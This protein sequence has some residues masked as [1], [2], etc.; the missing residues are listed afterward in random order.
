MKKIE[1]DSHTFSLNV[2]D[3]VYELI[4]SFT[5]FLTPFAVFYCDHWEL[6]DDCVIYQTAV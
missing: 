1:D 4:C 5:M 3:N 6:L 2:S